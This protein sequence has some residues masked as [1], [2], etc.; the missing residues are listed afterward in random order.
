MDRTR[1]AGPLTCR[2]SL[3]VLSLSSQSAWINCDS[4][5]EKVSYPRMTAACPNRQKRQRDRLGLG[6]SDQLGK[7]IVFVPADEGELLTSP[8][9][10]SN[11]RNRKLLTCWALP[12]HSKTLPCPRCTLSVQEGVCV[13]VVNVDPRATAP[14]FPKPPP[15]TGSGR[16]PPGPFPTTFRSPT[17]NIPGFPS[18][19]SLAT[20]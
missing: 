3:S 6:C 7:R 13:P 1:W 9:F 5:P 20:K 18:W 12:S 17:S 15:G 2:K 16:G 19:A 8:E 11:S 4:E 14:T 10:L